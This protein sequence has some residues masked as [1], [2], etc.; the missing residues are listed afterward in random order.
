MGTGEDGGRTVELISETK[1]RL[2][3]V[4]EVATQSNTSCSQKKIGKRFG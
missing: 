4:K 2:H 3:K 1:V